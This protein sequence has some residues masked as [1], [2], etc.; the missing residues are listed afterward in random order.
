[1][2]DSA[3]IYLA[4]SATDEGAGVAHYA[5]EVRADGG[6]RTPYWRR[7]R[8][9]M[10]CRGGCTIRSVRCAGARGAYQP[11]WTSRGSGKGERLGCV[12]A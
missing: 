2:S 4:W 9:R 6:N 10:C 3:D 1:M 8:T 7:T 12:L 5:V 11:T